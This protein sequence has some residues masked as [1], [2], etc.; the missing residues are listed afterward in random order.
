[1]LGRG[2]AVDRLVE[3][4]GEA[5]AQRA[6]RLQVGAA[7]HSELMKPVQDQMRERLAQVEWRDPQVPLAVNHS[8]ELASDAVEVREA[9]VAQIASPVLWVDCVRTLVD[10]GCDRFFELGPGRVLSGLV[11]Q[12]EPGVSVQA[13]E[14]PDALAEAAQASGGSQV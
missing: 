9:L 14:A 13:T 2:G 11:E 10:A 7:F 3:L 12:I 1:M 6:L 5:G 4:A 8:G